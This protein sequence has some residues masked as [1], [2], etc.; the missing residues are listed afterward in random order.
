MSNYYQP[1]KAIWIQN[2]N[3]NWKHRQILTITVLNIK[4]LT[5]K[6]EE[7]SR[8]PKNNEAYTSS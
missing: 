4:I 8:S 7:L 1:K 2:R 3:Y 5:L 6:F